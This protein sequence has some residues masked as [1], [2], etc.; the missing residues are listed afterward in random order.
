V[1]GVV[2]WAMDAG[3]AAGG[4]RLASRLVNW[5]GESSETKK[6][7]IEKWGWLGGYLLWRW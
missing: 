2:V 1:N 7:R 5:V 6:K 3:A 4:P